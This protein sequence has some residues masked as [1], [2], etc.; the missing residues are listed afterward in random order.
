MPSLVSRLYE[1]YGGRW[2][3]YKIV[4]RLETMMRKASAERNAGGYLSRLD[5]E[6]IASADDNNEF[7]L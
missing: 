3:F 6:A 2:D 4:S 5:G 1:L 7:N